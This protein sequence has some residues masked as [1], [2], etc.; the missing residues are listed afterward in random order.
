[1]K[2]SLLTFICGF[3][4]YMAFSQN[5]SVPPSNVRESFVKEYP[6][7]Q[8]PGWTHNSQGWT[9]NF[10]DKDHNDGEVVA[11]FDPRGRHLDSYIPYADG[12]VPNP[13]L[14][15]LHSRYPG[16]EGYEYTRIDRDGRPDLYRVQ[17]R[18][19]SRTHILYVDEKGRDREYQNRD[20]SH[21]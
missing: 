6:N 19:H 2:Y 13:V 16:A 5:E 12:D 15:R 3:G 21:R 18:N 4:F 11:H 7:S 14:K 20:W 17:V 1:M 10:E 8:S 9:V